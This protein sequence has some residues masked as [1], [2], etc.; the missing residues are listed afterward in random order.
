MLMGILTG[1]P[2]WV[3]AVLAGLIWFGLRMS[4][5]RTAPVIVIYLSPLIGLLSVNAVAGLP[6]WSLAWQAYGIAY[7][8]G[9]VGGY[10]LQKRWLIS[11]E[12]GKAV[13]AGEWFTLS[14]MMVIFWMNFVGGVSEA[15]FPEIY[16]GTAFISLFTLAAGLASGS[17]C[18]RAIR[19]WRA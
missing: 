6:G 4:K 1:A 15:V 10:V 13:L 9:I 19:V 14:V 7:A 8:F 18:G 2:L 3:W 5:D 16:A 12:D 17:F 11:K